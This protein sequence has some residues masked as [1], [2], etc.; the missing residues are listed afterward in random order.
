MY[1][2]GK[3][4]RRRKKIWLQ[5]INKMAI[6]LSFFKRSKPVS[7]KMVPSNE[8]TERNYVKNAETAVM[9]VVI[10]EGNDVTLTTDQRV[11][12]GIKQNVVEP[13]RNLDE[14]KRENV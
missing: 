10:E 6:S 8:T 4:K 14:K 5:P 9:I 13:L 12:M 3:R 1:I 11:V 2:A 7:K